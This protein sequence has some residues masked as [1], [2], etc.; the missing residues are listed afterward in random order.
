MSSSKD[1]NTV[2]YRL[3][4]IDP[5]AN[6]EDL[7]LQ[8]LQTLGP[9]IDVIWNAGSFAL[10]IQQHSTRPFLQGQLWFDN[11]LEDEWYVVW[12]L[13]KVTRELPVLAKVWDDD[14]E[15]LLIEGA[16]VLP[17][18]LNPDNSDNRVFVYQGACVLIPQPRTPAELSWFP[19]YSVTIEQALNCINKVDISSCRKLNE[20]VN[21]KL[22][23]FPTRSLHKIR[24]VL[25][26]SLVHALSQSPAL[27]S[28]IISVYLYSD[29]REIQHVTKNRRL[30]W[31]DTCAT[32][33]HLTRCQYAQ[34]YSQ[35]VSTASAWAHA[36]VGHVDHTATQLGLKI[37]LGAELALSIAADETVTDKGFSKYLKRLDSFGYFSGNIEGSKAHT[38]LLHRAEVFYRAS[39]KQDSG[40]VW[41]TSSRVLKSLVTQDP[42]SFPDYRKREVSDSA[43]D[44]WMDEM[45]QEIQKWFLKGRQLDTMQSDNI[46][47]QETTSSSPPLDH[48]EEIPINNV[49]PDLNSKLQGF[50][51]KISSHEGAE[52]P[53][54]DISFNVD[55]FMNCLRELKDTIDEVARQS[56]SEDTSSLESSSI[57]TESEEEMQEYMRDIDEQLK[58]TTLSDTFKKDEEGDVDI[59]LNLVSNILESFSAESGLSGPASSVL[60]SLGVHLPRDCEDIAG[61]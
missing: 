5:H 32:N 9:D 59:D 58:T 47:V 34:L 25:P 35:R 22:A 1:R 42:A 8:C 12:L 3:Y 50:I 54:P 29:Q 60:A 53:D 61:S 28:S 19:Q 33:L 37:T 2:F 15:F 30:D 14:G 20:T 16:E 13:Q 45:P 21:K 17:A 51:D 55:D 49:L 44:S 6:I 4:P 41:S 27:I 7:Q 36:P 39:Q 48:V 38:E 56:D 24:C 10:S 31:G 18:W 40:S 11:S 57:R 23:S 52:V 46:E 26:V 43:D